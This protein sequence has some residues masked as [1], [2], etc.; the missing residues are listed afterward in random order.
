MSSIFGNCL[1]QSNIE[2]LGWNSHV[3]PLYKMIEDSS[4]QLIIYGPEAN[5][6]G[7]AYIK[8][9]FPSISLCYIGDYPSDETVADIVVGESSI[10]RTVPKPKRIYDITNSLSGKKRQEI[11]CDSVCFT[12]SIAEGLGE[13]F[14]NILS[15]IIS[16]KTRFF[17]TKRLESFNYLGLVTD[18]ER[19]D[20]I[21][22][23][24]T[25]IDLTGDYWHKAIM[26]GCPTIVLSENEIAGV[27]TFT[28]IDSLTKVW[29]EVQQDNYDIEVSRKEV[30]NN[31]GHDLCGSLFASLGASEAAKSVLAAKDFILATKGEIV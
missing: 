30:I 29:S 2:I 24:K 16:K 28:D 17:G 19:A 3:I 11:L 26:A 27:P 10:R 8:Q 6:S 9:R 7:I 13:K 5:M 15:H 21:L 20:I 25:Y 31:T 14:R 4:P 22:S 18:Q 1:S 23:C 12:D